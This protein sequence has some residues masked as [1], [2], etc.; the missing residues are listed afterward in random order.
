VQVHGHGCGKSGINP[1]KTDAISKG[2][3]P[4]Q[5][6]HLSATL[7]RCACELTANLVFLRMSYPFQM[8]MQASQPHFQ[9]KLCTPQ[10]GELPVK[11]CY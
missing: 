6:T 7:Q 5:N 8:Q 3:N 10:L 9:L 1:L 4:S 2:N 11:I